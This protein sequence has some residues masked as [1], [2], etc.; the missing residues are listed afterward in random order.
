[1]AVLSRENKQ[2]EDAGLIVFFIRY[3]LM[4]LMLTAVSFA[5]LAVVYIF[6]DIPSNVLEIVTLAISVVVLLIVSFAV[7]KESAIPLTAGCVGLI[8]AA[9]RCLLAVIF[10]FVP[11][12]S[13]RTPFELVTGFLIGMIGGILGSS[14]GRR[15]TRR[16]R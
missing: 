7:G 2:K 10:G 8:Y 16:Y 11:F 3:V 12:L 15:R 5:V 13:V 4:A 9:V 14:G 1:M 6:I